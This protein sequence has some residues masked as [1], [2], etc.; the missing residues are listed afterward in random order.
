ML[1]SDTS[2]PKVAVPFDLATE[3]SRGIG[4]P[5]T[6]NVAAALSVISAG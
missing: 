6:V 1:G 5:M 2:M 4:L 3:S